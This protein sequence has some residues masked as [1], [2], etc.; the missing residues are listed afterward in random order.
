VSVTID[1]VRMLDTC[2]LLEVVK[3]HKC[4]GC[5]AGFIGIPCSSVIPFDLKGRCIANKERG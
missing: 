2:I 5:Q 3:Q 4:V 1:K